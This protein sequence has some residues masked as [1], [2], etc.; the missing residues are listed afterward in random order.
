MSGVIAEI[1]TDNYYRAYLYI[2][3]GVVQKMDG[4]VVNPKA[5]QKGK[6]KVDSEIE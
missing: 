2:L 3:L 6:E 1:F 5:K 4:K